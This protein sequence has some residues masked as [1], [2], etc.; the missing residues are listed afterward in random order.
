MIYNVIWKKDNTPIARIEAEGK[1]DL[2]EN[3]SKVFPKED[4]TFLPMNYGRV[5]QLCEHGNY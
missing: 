2:E 3:F 4:F 5:V 1:Y